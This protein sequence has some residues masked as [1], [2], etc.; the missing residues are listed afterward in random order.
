MH[1]LLLGAGPMAIEYAKVLKALQCSYT[2]VGRGESSAAKFYEA[3][4]SSVH[5][6][7]VERFLE[8]NSVVEY[9]A[10]IVAVSEKNLGDITRKLISVGIEKI[11]VEKPG[12]FDYADILSVSTEAKKQ[13]SQVW[14]GYNR[15]FY[16]STQK[17]QEI[18]AE[19]GGVKS[20][21]FEFTEWSHVISLLEKEEGV[22]EEWLLANSTHLIDL[23]FY[24]GGDPETMN[25]YVVGNLPWHSSG[26]IF[27]GS[28]ITST[29]ALF[30]YHANWESPGRW[31]LEIL[32]SRHRLIF[33][34]LEQLQ[35][36]KIG[37]TVIEQVDLDETKDTQFKPGL[38]HMVESLLSDC[39]GLLSIEDQVKK[40]RIYQQIKNG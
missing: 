15:R 4:G 9:D 11:L 3:I 31:G 10:A 5:V 36:Q 38:F 37:T 6:G 18:I 1:I 17:A 35:K 34:P 13:G 29:G 16:S 20:F 14:V 28:G 40:L 19:D 30:S 27:T 39:K 23:A 24:L 22:L 33:R 7:G 8:E 26:S 2:V 21:T 32:T 12:G 25:S